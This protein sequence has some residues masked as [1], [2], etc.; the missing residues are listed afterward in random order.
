MT[1]ADKTHPDEVSELLVREVS[2]TERWLGW[3]HVCKQIGGRGVHM[4]TRQAGTCV[5]VKAPV[6]IKIYDR[7]RVP[8]WGRQV[9]TAECVFICKRNVG[10]SV[11]SVGVLVCE[12][13]RWN[14]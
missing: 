10:M 11:R 7:C 6:C 3:R 4:C 1:N 5:C 9:T 13:V 2:G 8:Q 12:C 14:T